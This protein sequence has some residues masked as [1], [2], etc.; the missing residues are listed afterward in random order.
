MLLTL[1]RIFDGFGVEGNVDDLGECEP[2]YHADQERDVRAPRRPP[3]H[4]HI[5][6][7]SNYVLLLVAF[8]LIAKRIHFT[9][10]F[11][12]VKSTSLDLSL[13]RGPLI[14]KFIF[15]TLVRCA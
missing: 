14:G 1:P 9:L 8:R 13:L 7:S 11:N 2:K 5:L 12:V 6:L 10:H 4:I 15:A 3:F